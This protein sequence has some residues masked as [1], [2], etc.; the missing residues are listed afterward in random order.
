MS[1]VAF[2]LNETILWLRTKE[3][4]QNSGGDNVFSQDIVDPLLERCGG[5]RESERHDEVLKQSV[6]CSECRFPF[7]L[8]RYSDRV[9]RSSESSRVKRLAFPSLSKVC[10][11]SRRGCRF[12][13]V[14]SLSTR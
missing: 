11:M 13:P 4:A 3:L 8:F 5:V 14:F 12:L 10:C 2:F 9:V 1:Q 6:A 7:V